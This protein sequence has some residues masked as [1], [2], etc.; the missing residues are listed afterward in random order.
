MAIKPSIEVNVGAIGAITFTPGSSHSAVL[1]LKNPTTKAWTYSIQL[2]LIRPVNVSVLI[3]EWLNQAIA[4]GATVNLSTGA[5]VMPT[6][7]ASYQTRVDVLEMTTYTP[8]NFVFEDVVIAI[9]PSVEVVSL[10]WS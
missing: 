5:V 7:E 2:T 3:K 1:S 10:A 8:F 9:A 6:V 4:A